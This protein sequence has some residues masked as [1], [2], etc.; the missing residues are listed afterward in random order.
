MSGV[1]QASRPPLVVGGDPILK[2]ILSYPQDSIF[3]SDSNWPK[4]EAYS[5]S[6]LLLKLKSGTLMPSLAKSRTLTFMN[7][8]YHSVLLEGLRRANFSFR[9]LEG[10][11][12]GIRSHPDAARLHFFLN[13]RNAPAIARIFP[14]D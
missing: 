8:L 10:L 7:V 9:P 11:F 14:P 12:H 3:P 5:D 4:R 13:L 1:Y 6:H 2:D